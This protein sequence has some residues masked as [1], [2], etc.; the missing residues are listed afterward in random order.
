MQRSIKN[1]MPKI[2]KVVNKLLFSVL[3]RT[4]VIYFLL[5]VLHLPLFTQT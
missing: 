5:V 2:G 1:F 4:A 3:P